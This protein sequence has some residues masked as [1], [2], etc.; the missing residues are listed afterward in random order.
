[1]LASSA[2]WEEGERLLE[3]ERRDIQLRLVRQWSDNELGK[4]DA[5]TSWACA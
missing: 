5:G 1:M 3:S 4:G 2:G